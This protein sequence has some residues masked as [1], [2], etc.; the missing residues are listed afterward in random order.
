MPFQRG[1]RLPGERASKVGHLDVL[2]NPLVSELSRTFTDARMA[3]ADAES[4]WTKIEITAKPLSIIFCADGSWQTIIGESPPYSA[5]A[6]IKTA[7]VRLD[8]HALG[9]VDK[10]SPNPFVLRDILKESAMHHA[11]VFPL[12]HVV[13]KGKT[14]YDAIRHA[15][16]ISLKDD[17][18]LESQ[19]YETFK[20]IVYQKWDATEN[21][22]IPPFECP[23]CGRNTTLPFDA[24]VGTCPNCSKE[25]FVTDML[26]FHQEMAP[27]A[28]QDSVASS[29]MAIH[30][31]LMLLTGVRYFWERNK[32]LLTDCLFIKD[33]PLS[34]RAQYSKLVEPIR[35]FISFARKKEMDVHIIGQEKTG[36]FAD[37]LELIRDHAPFP[38]CFAPDDLYIKER[39]QHRSSQGAPYGKDTNYGAKVF[40]KLN[41]YHSMVL[42]VPTGEFEPNPAL[43]DLVG[44]DR[45]LATLPKILSNRYEGA[46]M[47][48]ELAN[49]VA[50]LSTYPSARILKIFS[51]NVAA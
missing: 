15:I 34:I 6:F 1:R 46:L 28:A 40:V 45:I 43:S 18:V 50:S 51:E 20:W 36:A 16:F 27:D 5:R 32:K 19:P 30:E 26:G 48:V 12:R 10:E 25:I 31:T 49:G 4:L 2:K 47:P 13:C 38:T 42:N 37:H 8:E 39:I 14:L 17:R 21:R 41:A 33:G 23:H 9:K 29:Y 24:D 35:R 11:T 22:P 3:S 44:F 7:L